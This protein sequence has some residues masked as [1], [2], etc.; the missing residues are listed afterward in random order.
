MKTKDG[1]GIM[2]RIEGHERG[3][4]VVLS[5]EGEEKEILWFGPV[6]FSVCLLLCLCIALPCS[7]A[8]NMWRMHPWRCVLLAAAIAWGVLSGD[9]TL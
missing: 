8:S 2:T 4:R 1:G 5:G 6:V 3:V 7:L 9:L